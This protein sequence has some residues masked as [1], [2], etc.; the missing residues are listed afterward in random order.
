MRIR[1]CCQPD[2]SMKEEKRGKEREERR[3][4]D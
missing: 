4:E 2:C 3:E 1:R